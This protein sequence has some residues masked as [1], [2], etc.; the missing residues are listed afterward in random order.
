MSRWLWR[1]T[2]LATPFLNVEVPVE[3]LEI[4]QRNIGLFTPEQ[5]HRL[6]DATVI[7]A[8]AR[9]QCQTEAQTLARF[10]VGEIRLLTVPD[11][12]DAEPGSG[13][14]LLGRSEEPFANVIRDTTP[15]TSVRTL[16]M[17]GASTESL[18]EFAGGAAIIIDTLE[19]ERMDLKTPL[20]D[21]ARTMEIFLIATHP[22][23]MGSLMVVFAPGGK[24][25][26]SWYAAL[27][28]P[29][30]ASG[31]TAAGLA[32]K[33]GMG[34]AEAALILTGMRPP[35]DVIAAPEYV[36]FNALD[37]RFTRHAAPNTETS[38]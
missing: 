33:A 4:F 30:P 20:A 6:K 10:G 35:A 18:Q 17:A 36:T 31:G 23:P 15:H 7:V 13:P 5:Q 19:P 24:T 11:D 3:Y 29:I 28:Q 32:L 25:P 27:P 34:A 16:D 14:D 1:D 12:S 21:L 22:L 38:R 8:G 2:K 37:R 9:D 26:E